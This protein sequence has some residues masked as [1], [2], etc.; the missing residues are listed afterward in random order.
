MINIRLLQKSDFEQYIFLINQFRP[1]NMDI[2]FKKFDEIYDIIFK[3]SEIYV[4][5]VDEKIVG[6]IT[7][8]YEQKFIH[9]LSVYAHI[10]DVIVDENSRYMRIGSA[11]LSYVKNI[12]H[13]KGCFKCLL[14]CNENVKQFYLKNLFEER[15]LNLSFLL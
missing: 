10:E 11:M 2:T 1:I 9:K 13:Q 8:F 4:A 5:C 12:T 7:V 14:V 6:S 3:S 15:G